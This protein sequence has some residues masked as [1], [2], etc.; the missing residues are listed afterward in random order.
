[1]A[2]GLVL[3]A[4]VVF[5]AFVAGAAIGVVIAVSVAIHREDRRMSLR[6]AAPGW[7][8][9]GARRLNGVGVRNDAKAQLLIR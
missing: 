4:V 7:L 5:A 6:G 9:G 1:M 3:A 2:S 8:S